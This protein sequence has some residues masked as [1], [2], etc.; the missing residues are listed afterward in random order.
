MF[1]EMRRKK[2]ALERRECIRILQAGKNGVLAL[3]GDENYP[4]AL[5]MN[6]VYAD[7][8]IYFHCAPDGHKMDALRTCDRVSFC[9]IDADQVDAQHYSTRYRSVIAFGRARIVESVSEKRCA[10]EAIGNRFCPDTPEKT[11]QEIQS[12]LARTAVIE[13]Q[14]EHLSGKESRALAQARRKAEEN[15]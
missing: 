3:R 15:Q 7:E 11:V 6:Y 8:K 12:A 1:R 10:L 4:Y 2:Q 14:I 9:V 5:P 13:M